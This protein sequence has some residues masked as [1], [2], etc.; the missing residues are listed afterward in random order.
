[1]C[2]YFGG[3]INFEDFDFG[4]ILLDKKLC[5]NILIYVWYK[6]FIGAKPLCIVLDK[7]NWR[8]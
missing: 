5:E 7:V 4:N 6:T 1:M 3:M 2:Y 8:L